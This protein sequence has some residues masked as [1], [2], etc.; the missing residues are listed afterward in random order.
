MP[1]MEEQRRLSLVNADDE[2]AITR[3]YF[4]LEERGGVLSGHKNKEGTQ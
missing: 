4:P 2:V 1:P 3:S